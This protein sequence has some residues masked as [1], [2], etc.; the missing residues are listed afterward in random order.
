MALA[1]LIV[2]IIVPVVVLVVS[3]GVTALLHRRA[4]ERADRAN[5]NAERAIEME[6]KRL[7]RE[8]ATFV[9]PVR[10]DPAGNRVVY[11]LVSTWP[12]EE[13]EF[14]YRNYANVGGIVRKYKV[15]PGDI[16]IGVNEF[17]GT[18]ELEA[19]GRKEFVARAR[20]KSEADS[21]WDDSGTYLA[22]KGKLEFR[23]SS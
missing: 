16:Y 22:V 6:R 19:P 5:A 3:S 7:E 17:E 14:E 4:M 23:R 9:Q 18:G 10:Y 12:A 20:W 2:A 13:V 15:P 11:Q 1:A 8:E 21:E